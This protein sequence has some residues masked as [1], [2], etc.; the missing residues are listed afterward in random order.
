M[1]KFKRGD[2]VRVRL[3]TSSPYRGR[4]GIVDAEPTQ[5]SYD[6]SYTLKFESQGFTRTYLFPE[7]DLES[8]V[9]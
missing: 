8:V 6:L 4:I 2:K 5:D 3:D 7:R 9:D 1:T